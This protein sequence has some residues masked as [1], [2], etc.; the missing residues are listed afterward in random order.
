MLNG[1]SILITGGTGSFGRMFV[2]KIIQSYS[3]VKRIVV[4]SRGELEQ[5]KMQQIYP[6]DRY[7]QMRFF[8]GDV[9][10]AERVKQACEGIDVII[11]A[12]AIKQV[13]TAEYNPEE[14]IKTNVGGAQNVIRA[15]LYC[16]VK[17]VVALSTDKACAPINLY[18]ATKLTSDKLFIAANNIKG[19][20]NI[21]FSV[22]RYGNV[23][24]SRG[25]VIPFFI[26]RKNQGA[27]YLPITDRRMTR[28]NIS[29]DAGVDLVMYAI[30]HH[31]GGEIFLPKIPSYRIIDVAQAIAPDIPIKQIGIRPGEKL[32]E[33]M[34]TIT[35]ALNTLD[36]GDYYAILPTVSFN[37]TPK[38]YIDHYNANYVPE[39]FHYSSGENSD[40]ETVESIREKIRRYVDPCFF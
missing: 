2:K 25:S 31:L 15:A 21:K 3:D 14:C 34:I 38:E 5:Y 33:E 40:W 30:G 9:R 23:M 12:A 22:V 6:A 26:N 10:D 20:R 19:G 1:K 32:H 8:I 18:G 29:L 37:H 35:D 36:L 7:P 17:H 39:G 11:H 24:G 28:F 13:D 16:G 4:F 27:A